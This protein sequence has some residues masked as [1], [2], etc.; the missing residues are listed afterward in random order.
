MKYSSI[1]SAQMLL[2]HFKEQGVKNI[3]ISP[4]SRNAPLTI[5]FSEHPYFSCFSVVDERCAAFFALGMA[6]QLQEPVAVLCTSGSALLNY[7]PAVA[8]AFFSQIPLIVVSAD[9]PP[10]K[11]DIG[12]GQ[13]IRQ[14][15]VFARHIAYEANLLI[16]VA[17]ATDKLKK[18]NS[19][20][21]KEGTSVQELQEDINQRNA[22]E[23]QEAFQV[24][25]NT[26][27]PIHINIPFEEPLYDTVETLYADS[28]TL[29]K[30]RKQP[31]E[32]VPLE[33]YQQLW[34]KAQKKMIIV[35]VQTPNYIEQEIL[36]S[37]GDDPSV[38]V[39]TETTSNIHHPNFFYSIDAIIAPIE[40]SKEKEVLFATLQPEILIT[41]GG[42]IVSKKIKAFLRTFKPKHHWHVGELG[43]NDTF[44]SL[45]HHFK[46][47]ENSFFRELLQN[48][49]SSKSSY[50]SF[51]ANRKQQ[52]KLKRAAYLEQIPFSDM[53]AF[54]HIL[55]SIPKAYQLHLAN[56]ST[57]RYAQ[58]FDLDPSLEVYCNRGTS[59]IDGSSST[60]VG[61]SVYYKKPSV[62]ITGDVSFF[63]DSNAFWNAYIPATFRVILINN[64][65]GGI[66][67]I[68][69][70]AE[71]SDNFR[72][73][74]E[75]HHQLTA[76]HLCKM[77][78]IKYLHA[79]DEVSLTDRLADLYQPSEIPVLLEITTPRLINDKIL[80]SYFDF[81]S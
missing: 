8:E 81:I 49:S 11:I 64:E 57:V 62:L 54:H 35:G 26:S 34:Q 51:W 65:G 29:K 70:G 59:G 44:F 28:T 22:N 25:Y 41:F 75:T 43:A 10:H 63:Y 40:K 21:F 71:E 53:V 37:L 55:K 42:L 18:E 77:Y 27:Q 39:F 80:R 67:R 61:A 72:T 74:F 66:F 19:S 5:S 58:L 20:L 23:L 52:Y 2:T 45:S 24:L 16:D 4:G 46:T 13:T 47:N 32:S 1:P 3:I 31:L 36:N 6:M 9:R 68:L 17:H 60:A 14:E 76:E 73:Y 69:P 12:D 30:I 56:S 33:G 78:N 38:I 15:H 50:K 79:T 7:Y 48:S